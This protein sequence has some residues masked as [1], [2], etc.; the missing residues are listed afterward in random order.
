MPDHLPVLET[1][2]FN[3]GGPGTPVVLRTGAILP[4]VTLAYETYGTL[5]P[6]ASNAILLFHAMTGSQ[7]AAGWNPSVPG[8]SVEWNDE[9][10]TGWWDAFIGSGKALDTDKYFVICA[11]YLGGCYGSTGPSSINPETGAAF[12]ASFPRLEFADIVDSQV[13]LLDHLGIHRVR[14]VCGASI[15]G[16]MALEF[17]VR[18]PERSESAILLASGMEVQVLQRLMNFE[19]I[20]AIE[21]DGGFLGGDYLPGPGPVRGLA[22]AR[23]IAHKTFISFD[24]LGARSRDE[25]QVPGDH[26]GAYPLTHPVESYML[27]QANKFVP[28]FDAN[29]YL[30]IVEAWQRFDLAH[31]SGVPDLQSGLERCAGLR[32]LIFSI[33]SDVCFYPEEQERLAQCLELAGADVTLRRVDSAKGHDSFLLEPELYEAGI[34][35]LL[36]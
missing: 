27:H 6:D 30:R 36:G 19:Q 1:R 7:H 23:I 4:D 12:G 32:F 31:A 15:G 29:S 33:A 26:F 22:L 35:D 2:F 21:C 13:K 11:N 20:F 18:F 9:C 5:A 25:I 34:R 28:R 24:T 14:A 10:Q 16:L 3:Y 8:L 17:S